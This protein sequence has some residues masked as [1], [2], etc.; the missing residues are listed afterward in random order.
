MCSSQLRRLVYTFRTY[1]FIPLYS[2]S[3]SIP[4]MMKFL[5]NPLITNALHSKFQLAN[6][7]EPFV[8]VQDQNK[9]KGSACQLHQRM[10]KR[11]DLVAHRRVV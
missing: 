2:V 1:R 8:T 9:V 3:H 6:S 5:L 10:F 7:V 11:G 4:F